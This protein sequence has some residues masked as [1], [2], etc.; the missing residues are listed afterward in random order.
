MT[1]S[2][3][4]VVGLPTGPFR[5]IVADPPW[6]YAGKTPPWRST[7][8]PT[9]DLMPL[10]AICSLPVGQIATGDAHLYLWAVLP[11]MRE[12]YEVV[13]AWGFTPETVLTWCKPGP[14]L[15]G[16]FRG[17]TEHLIVARRGWSAVNP[18]CAT[19]GGRAR[20][21]RKCG[22]ENP[23]WRV[24]GV[25]LAETDAQRQSFTGTGDGTWFVAQRREHS[26][27]PELFQ[28]LIERMSPGPRLELFA[29]RQRLGWTVW[30]NEVPCRANPTL[31][32]GG[33]S[34][35]ETG[36]KADE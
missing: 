3:Q 17:N 35:N 14:G 9:Y 5:C 7:S 1:P 23:A 13:E 4:N 31:H 22:C 16:G 21:A 8:T 27:K 28:D 30:G 20:G 33:T 6:D 18:T 15:G 26:E 24:K 2:L 36:G 11:M 29:R 19:C 25:P 10:D 32:R 12:A 34:L